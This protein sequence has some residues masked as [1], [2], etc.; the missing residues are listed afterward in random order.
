MDKVP[1]DILVTPAEKPA[2]GQV[3]LLTLGD[4]DGRTN[5][6]KAARGMIAGIES[7][8]G[9]GDRLSTGERILAARAGVAAAMIE[10][11]EAK[12]LSG[13]PID[14]NSY[15]TLVN[16]LGRTLRTLGLQRRPAD[17]ALDLSTY[18]ADRREPSCPSA[19]RTI[20]VEGMKGCFHH[21]AAAIFGLVIFSPPLQAADSI[22][23]VVHIR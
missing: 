3:K 4:L 9:G 19:G 15:A 1:D 20:A 14:P 2:K 12:W 13:R 18:V 22:G 8:L 7:D 11:A 17:T 23:P 21:L 5:A 6:A 16:V 10:D